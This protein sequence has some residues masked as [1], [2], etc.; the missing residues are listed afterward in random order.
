MRIIYTNDSTSS[1]K[2]LKNIFDLAL[3]KN[4]LNLWLAN[5]Y[6]QI[7]EYIRDG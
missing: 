1:K 3:N 4:K 7:Y 6:D 5:A 2:K